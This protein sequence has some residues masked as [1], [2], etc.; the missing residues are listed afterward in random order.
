MTVEDADRWLA[1]VRVA[2]K[3]R[4]RTICHVLGF[5]FLWAH[6]HRW[7]SCLWERYE[8]NRDKLDLPPVTLLALGWFV[9]LY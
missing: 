3:V 1:P 2:G 9:V 7:W 6:H 4:F 8:P 5:R